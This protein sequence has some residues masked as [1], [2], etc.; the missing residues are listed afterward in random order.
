MIRRPP[1]STPGRTLFPYTTLFRSTHDLLT[2]RRQ[3]IPFRLRRVIVAHHHGT[4]RHESQQ[5][6]DHHHAKVFPPDHG[7]RCSL[8][9][10][11]QFQDTQ[12]QEHGN[13]DH[14]IQNIFTTQQ[15]ADHLVRTPGKTQPIRDV[16]DKRYILPYLIHVIQ[17]GQIGRASCRERVYV[18]V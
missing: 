6:R 16:P 11:L 12:Q 14:E 8:P 3:G 4:R 5:H 7:K 13:H 1:R 17:H 10:G 18:L 2:V 15:T 9:R